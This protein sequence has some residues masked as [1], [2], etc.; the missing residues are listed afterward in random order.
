MADKKK[1]VKRKPIPK[2]FLRTA[3]QKTAAASAHKKR[4]AL[5]ARIPDNQTKVKDFT[6]DHKAALKETRRKDK[7]SRDR[8]HGVGQKNF[9][10]INKGGGRS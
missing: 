1:P 4:Q 7:A 5:K 6:P 3:T 10:E 2:K 8:F 9:D